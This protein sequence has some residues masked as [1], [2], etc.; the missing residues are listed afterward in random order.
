[1]LVHFS[2]RPG[3]RSSG[4]VVAALWS[5]A[6]AGC[7][8]VQFGDL[9]YRP[10]LDTPWFADGEGPVVAI[11]AAHN[12]FHTADGRYSP[13][14]RLLRADGCRVVSTVEPFTSGTLDGVDLLVIANALHES[15]VE[16]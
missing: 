1:M 16:E 13:F 15:D 11:D 6:P 14:A 4:I 12:N 10:R 5:L 2:R 9:D 8:H 7:G 3:G